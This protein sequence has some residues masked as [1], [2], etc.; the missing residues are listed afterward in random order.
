[1]EKHSDTR[2]HFPL[3]NRVFDLTT[4]ANAHND[5]N[6]SPSHPSKSSNLIN[7]VVLVPALELNVSQVVCAIRFDV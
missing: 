3:D 5:I 2:A 1:M 7:T 6:Y 4:S